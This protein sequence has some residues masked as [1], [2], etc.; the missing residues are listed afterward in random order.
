MSEKTSCLGSSVADT[1]S[2]VPSGVQTYSEIL[3]APRTSVVTALEAASTTWKRARDSGLPTTTAS[4]LSFSFFSSSSVF[5]AVV[6][7]ARRFPS[8]AQSKEDMPVLLS[9][10]ARASPPSTAMR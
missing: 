6:S 2:D 3:Q 7:K 10:R 1:T 9:V 8:G 5:G 4:S